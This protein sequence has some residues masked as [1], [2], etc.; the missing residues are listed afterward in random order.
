MLPGLDPTPS[1]LRGS[2]DIG[3][4]YRL[5]RATDTVARLLPASEAVALHSFCGCAGVFLPEDHQFKIT[6][7]ARLALPVGQI[8]WCAWK[9]IYV[10]LSKSGREP[11]ISRFVKVKFKFT[12]Q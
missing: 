1:P 3:D 5:L 4:G 10:G 12:D 6:K 7:W 9:E 2:L 11:R 8:A